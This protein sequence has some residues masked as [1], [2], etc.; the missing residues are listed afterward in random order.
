MQD[1]C[2][3]KYTQVEE[4]GEDEDEEGDMEIGEAGSLE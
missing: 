4:Y 1:A 3:V 2:F